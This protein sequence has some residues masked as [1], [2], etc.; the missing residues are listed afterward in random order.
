M[1]LTLPISSLLFGF[2]LFA[3][4]PKVAG[5]ALPKFDFVRQSLSK[6]WRAAHDIAS[7][8]QTKAGMEIAISG[9][10]PYLY[11]PVVDFPAGQ[12]LWLNL[13]IKS[14]TGGT[15]QVFYFK[16]NPKEEDS[17]HF[18]CR[19]EIWEDIRIP[20]PALGDGLL[21]RIDPPGT[22]G[23]CVISNL[24]FE[25]RTLYKEPDWAA[26]DLPR[27]TDPNFAVQSGDLKMI[28]SS[29]QLNDFE[30]EV[31]GEK[32][33]IGYTHAPI[34]I[35][36]EGKLVWL[37]HLFEKML[38]SR[39]RRSGNSIFSDLQ[40]AESDGAVW[41]LSQ[42]YAP[43]KIPGAIDVEIRWSVSKDREILFLPTLVVFPGVG[44]FGDKKDHAL[45]AG[46]EY[47]DKNELSSSEADIRGVGSRRQ[48]PDNLRITFPLMTVQANDRYVGIGWKQSPSLT[49]I[50]DTPDRHFHSGG[51]VMGLIFPGSDGVSREEG[52]LLPYGPV[53]LKAG[54]PLI[55]NATIY[56]GTG[57]SVIPSMQSYVSL[58]GLPELPKTGLD[59]EKYYSLASA[60]WLDSGIGK[61][62]TYRHAL[63]G[64]FGFGPAAD[65]ATYL[66]WLSQQT[67]K[68]E[69]S[70]RLSDASA[71][72]LAKA[73]QN[74]L[75]YSGISHI[76]TP[77]AALLYGHLEENM[78]RA[79]QET[80]GLLK[81]F[82]SD[83][84]VLY[85]K[86]PKGEDL[87]RT[88]FAPD[89]NG[90]T[91]TVVAT[92]LEKAS[93]CGS[94]SLIKEGLKLLDKLDKFENSAPR[95]AQ[96]WEVPL[97]TPDILASAYLIKAYTLGYALSGNPRYL[98][99][100][101]HW[102]WTGVPF[103]YIAPPNLEKS[104]P[105]FSGAIP[106]L[107]VLKKDPVGVYATIAVFGA[108]QWV[109]PNWMGLPVQWCGLVYAESLYELYENDPNPIWKQLA[110]GIT[111]SAIQ[112][113]YPIGKDSLR[114]GLLPDSFNLRQ[115]TQNDA[116][117]NPGTTQAL[118]VR[119]LTG[120]PLSEMR[121]LPMS[122]RIVAHY[123]GKIE[124]IQTSDSKASFKLKTWTSKPCS[125]L[126]LG[127]KKMPTISIDRKPVPLNAPHRFDLK[128]GRLILQLVGNHEIQITP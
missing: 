111:L 107:P 7:I 82:E 76:R 28:V 74:D 88:H 49:A 26:P 70:Q 45:L 51:S 113:A 46:L 92:L 3:C 21:L 12:T 55:V 90:L 13:R 94:E 98:E 87:G 17:V 53:R 119:L 42:K 57:K 108:T 64:S 37:D 50:F 93:F 123:P 89:A 99:M 68:P 117:I 29:A 84:S 63:P 27:P 47:L 77:A 18:P 40:L 109:S 101:K 114:Q 100:A 43:S 22:T 54:V 56:G 20:I 120:V 122:A 67:K 39:A 32:M 34:G 30:I 15:G 96:T 95:G 10:D 41:E 112:Q 61:D 78:Q 86:N 85:R 52:S 115:Q 25:T 72:A 1:K 125:L 66:D 16:N 2:L 69:R 23:N 128:S 8:R 9:E 103:V 75:A 116:S 62:G 118:A 73:P 48:T 4:M 104:L 58:N 81:Q 124:V 44:S 19:A 127:F 83:G 97:H 11:S 126:L 80:Q 35:Q 121:V 14:E 60:G 105:E 65:V 38:F 36:R 5:Q 106:P 59:L 24:T 33:A 102:A 6:D 31:K 91:A 110:D 71:Q 79:E